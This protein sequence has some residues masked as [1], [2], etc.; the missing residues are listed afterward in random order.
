MAIPIIDIFAGPGGLGEGFSALINEENENVFKISLS[1]EKDPLAHQT[2]RLRSFYRQFR[3]EEVPEDYYD[4]VKGL[5]SI[6]ELYR[7]WPIQAAH[8]HK[9]AWCGT[10]GDPDKMDQNAVSDDE[11]DARIRQVLNGE[12]NWLLIGG[13]PCQAYSLVGRSRRQETILDETNDKRVGLYK[14]YLRILAQHSPAVFVMENVKGI[15]SAQTKENQVFSKILTDLSDPAA[16]YPPIDDEAH[17]GCPGYRIFSLISEPEGFRED[18]SPVYDQ[19]NFVIKAEE[20]GIPQT[21]HRVILLG[22]R[23]DIQVDPGIIQKSEEINISSVINSL[24][25]LRSGLSK[26][27]DSFDAWLTLIHQILDGDLLDNVDPEIVADIQAKI[28]C[29]E[30]PRF[31]KGHNYLDVPGIDIEYQPGWFLDPRLNGV[32]NHMSRSHMD[33]DIHRYLFVSCFGNIKQQSP[34]LSDFPTALLPAHVNVNEGIDDKKFADRFR[35]Q[36]STKASKTVT[37]HISKDGH[38]YIHPDPTQC[39]SLTVREAARIQTFPDNYF[40]C[41]P[42]TSQFHQVG[43][44]VPPYLAY[45]IAGVVRQVFHELEIL[46]AHHI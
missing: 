25:R 38:Y 11:V 46:A 26:T 44:A 33:S 2:L 23:R 32:L 43:N 6:E 15:L 22:I 28:Q 36:L 30:N 31:G 40:F 42:R 35:V 27:Q 37:S 14:Q 45:Q 16:C 17:V 41:G 3:H 24:P 1:I 9:E 21:R 4:F 19:N 18:G 13:P 7:R 8:A 34:K 12:P 5:L 29:I 39:R 10:L 20:Y